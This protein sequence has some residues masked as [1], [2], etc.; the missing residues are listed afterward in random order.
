M[1][2]GVESVRELFNLVHSATKSAQS[3]RETA[4]ISYR[5]VMCA[6]RIDPIVESNPHAEIT[7]SVSGMSGV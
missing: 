3:V 4:W 5:A 6:L 7:G 1:K 2:P